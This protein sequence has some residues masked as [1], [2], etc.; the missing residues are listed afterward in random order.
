MEFRAH[1]NPVFT[2]A[3]YIYLN[4]TC[5]GAAVSGSIYKFHELE[6][7]TSRAV[8]QPTTCILGIKYNKETA[9]QLRLDSAFC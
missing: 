2:F 8:I 3:P 1:L 6:P 4:D 5:R 7:V 9:L